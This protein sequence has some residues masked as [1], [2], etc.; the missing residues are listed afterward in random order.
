VSEAVFNGGVLCDK[1]QTFVN[2]DHEAI[3]VRD[4]G[5][6]NSDL[7]LT[8]EELEHDHPFA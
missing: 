5:P 1:A 2:A 8:E 3:A 7:T 6:E 4:P